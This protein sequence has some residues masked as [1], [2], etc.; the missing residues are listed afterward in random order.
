MKEEKTSK[1]SYFVF[2]IFAIILFGI[3]QGFYFY[4]KDPNLY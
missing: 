2:F 1:T 3:N 4:F